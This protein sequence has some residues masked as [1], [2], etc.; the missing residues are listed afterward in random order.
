[1]AHKLAV[2]GMLVSLHSLGLIFASLFTYKWFIDNTRDV[3]IFGICEYLNA[4]SINKMVNFNS[5]LI[6]NSLELVNAYNKSAQTLQPD[7]KLTR[8]RGSKQS[9]SLVNDPLFEALK[10]ASTTPNAT[11]SSISETDNRNQTREAIAE[12]LSAQ[13]TTTMTAS[14]MKTKAKQ[15][16]LLA[17]SRVYQKCYQLL[18]PE[19]D[20]SFEYLASERR[21]KRCDI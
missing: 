21:K 20:E 10:L 2:L 14:L 13:S 12:A 7:T 8:V 9:N 17:Y 11:N 16:T 6:H 1:M 18:W 5:P 4:S 3:G 19:N 15:Y